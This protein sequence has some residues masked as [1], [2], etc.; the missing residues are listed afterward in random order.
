MR[1]RIFRIEF[2]CAFKTSNRLA[3]AFR[4]TTRRV[5]TSRSVELACLFVFTCQRVG[6][7]AQDLRRD[8]SNVSTWPAPFLRCGLFLREFANQSRMAQVAQDAL[9]RRFATQWIKL[10]FDAQPNNPR[11]SDCV[12][13]QQQLQRTF[14]LAEM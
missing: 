8:R 9:E 11:V 12:S 1:D 2:N 3:Q 10:G 5:I 6:S 13:V 4:G 14:A 7:R